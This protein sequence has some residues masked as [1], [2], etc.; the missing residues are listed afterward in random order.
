MLA[1]AAATLLILIVPG[2]SVAHVVARSLRYGRAAG[3]YSMLGLEFGAALHVVFA[4]AGLA[5]LVASSPAAIDVIRWLGAAYLVWLG[6]RQLTE[7]H[8]GPA[9][10][11][12][13]GKYAATTVMT[14]RRLFIEGILVDLL[15][16]KTALFFLAFLPQFVRVEAGPAAPQVL[17]LG[18]CFI[19]LAAI[20]DSLYAMAAGGLSDRFH[21]SPRA[22]HVVRTATSGTYLGLA[23]LA[24]FS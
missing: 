7:R 19:V 20:C 23:A 22:E 17:A 4:A 12:A 13:G 8:G 9:D 10:H 5:A 14:R 16:P 2:P 1:F 11:Q 18:S 24:A 6:V 15:N 21:Q 3:L